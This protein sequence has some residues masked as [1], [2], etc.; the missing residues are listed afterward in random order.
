MD[1]TDSR[2]KF[3]KVVAPHLADGFAL[4]RWLSGHR[5]DAEDILQEA[6]IRAFR[7]IDSFSGGSARAWV[8]TIVRRT[9]YSWLGKNR[10]RALVAIED[11]SLSE[12]TLAERG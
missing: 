9:T 12:R 11:L 10:S 8:L 4:A 1:D 6:C 5:A 3:E 7:A 2:A